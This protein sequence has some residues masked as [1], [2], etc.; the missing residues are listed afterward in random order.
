MWN[1]KETNGLTI[2]KL[3]YKQWWQSPISVHWGGICI[4]VHSSLK[5]F[6]RENKALGAVSRRKGFFF[7]FLFWPVLE[8][9]FVGWREKSRCFHLGENGV[10]CNIWH[11]FLIWVV[12]LH[13]KNFSY[14]IYTLGP[15]CT[16][17]SIMENYI[18]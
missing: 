18:C 2:S 5:V 3:F 13:L 9:I 10:T 17:S 8:S 7:F 11:V 4:G 14:F 15:N 6:S 12:M 16:C 1:E